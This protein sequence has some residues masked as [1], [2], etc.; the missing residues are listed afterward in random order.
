MNFLKSVIL[1]IAAIFIVV[2]ISSAQHHQ[3]NTFSENFIKA[4][5]YKNID[6]L[7]KLKPNPDLWRLI[8]E[9]ETK[10][11]TDE[12]INEKA[13]KNEKFIQDFDNIMYSAKKEKIDL[14]KLNFKRAKVFEIEG[15]DKNRSSI[16]IKYSYKGKEAEFSLIVFK[17][18]E[19]YYLSEILIS[20]DIFSEL[21]KDR[22][23]DKTE[24]DQF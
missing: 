19:E 10:D 17:Y 16:T 12:E 4:L 18:N 7:I 6:A 13:N 9:K 20:Y 1:S 3:G 8:L 11:M 22:K 21:N 23:Y 14:T 5:E 2:S 24:D 15:D